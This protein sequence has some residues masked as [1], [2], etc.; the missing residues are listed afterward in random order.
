MARSTGS[1]PSSVRLE[2]LSEA[3]SLRLTATVVA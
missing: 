3:D 2:T 1:S